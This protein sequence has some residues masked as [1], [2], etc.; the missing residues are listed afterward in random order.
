M[1]D[2]GDTFTFETALLLFDTFVQSLALLL[3]TKSQLHPFTQIL[4]HIN[5]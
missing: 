3:L 1:Q 2:V 4:K 5:K